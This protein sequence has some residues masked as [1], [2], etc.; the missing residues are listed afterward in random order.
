[1]CLSGRKVSGMPKFFGTKIQFHSCPLKFLWLRWH[2]YVHSKTWSCWKKF[3][4]FDSVCESVCVNLRE[5][6]TRLTN[7]CFVAL[8]SCPILMSNLTFWFSSSV[9]FFLACD[10]SSPPTHVIFQTPKILKFFSTWRSCL[11][12]Q[13]FSRQKCRIFEKLNFGCSNDHVSDTPNSKKNLPLWK[14]S[15]LGAKTTFEKCAK[16]FEVSGEG[17]PCCVG[18]RP[19]ADVGVDIRCAWCELWAFAIGSRNLLLLVR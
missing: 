19:S 13:F 16:F 4:T 10:E 1:M 5:F 3:L 14:S 17:C 15:H 18:D 11:T 12:C 8:S 7:E 6:A 2:S 9:T